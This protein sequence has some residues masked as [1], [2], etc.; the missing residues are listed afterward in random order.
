MGRKIKPCSHGLPSAQCKP[1][2]SAYYRSRYTPKTRK[3]DKGLINKEIVKT[4][5]LSMGGCCICS[6]TIND[7]NVH[8]FALDHREPA[9][10]LFNLSQA[11]NKYSPEMVKA[12]C[13]KCDL[14][15]H[16]CH[17]LK[18]HKEGDHK[19]RKDEAIAQPEY[20]PLL[21]LM[22]DTQ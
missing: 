2:R 14:M 6:I 1:C 8:M 21:L 19:F 17:H 9:L 10:K 18:T 4:Y 16:N 7:S 5:K 3:I 22:Q 11:K 20:L 13:A 12:E 15:C